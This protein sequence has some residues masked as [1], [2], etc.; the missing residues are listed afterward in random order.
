MKREKF[1][2]IL[3]FLP[4]IVFNYLSIESKNLICSWQIFKCILDK[5]IDVISYVSDHFN[6]LSK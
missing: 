5:V 4:I 3:M 1:N 6:I 2:F